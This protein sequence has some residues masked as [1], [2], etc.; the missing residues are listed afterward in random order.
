MRPGWA[1][2]RVSRSQDAVPTPSVMAS[3]GSPPA[4]WY[5]DPSGQ[6]RARYWD[7]GSWT[8][9]V[10]DDVGAPSAVGG[11]Q[12]H[13]VAATVAGIAQALA[14]VAE[15]DVAEPPFVVD[16]GTA[17]PTPY[18][19]ADPVPYGVTE[20]PVDTGAFAM[21]ASPVVD[22]API[23][24]W[25]PDPS[26]RHQARY[27][28]GFKWTERVA[29]NGT[30]S[31]DPVPGTEVVQTTTTATFG[32]DPAAGWSTQMIGETDLDAAFAITAT[33]EPPAMSAG[34]ASL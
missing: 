6:H 10:R 32:A 25:Y 20:T 28:D 22:S 34:Q 19:T 31:M 23:A 27:W 33:T 17:D 7:G 9:Q 29:D 30:E 18:R 16:Y 24:G 13:E 3:L 5:T 21:A 15:Q 12:T 26:M 2:K 14:T 1:K 11:Q 8:E 4:G